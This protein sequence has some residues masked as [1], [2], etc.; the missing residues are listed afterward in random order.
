MSDQTKSQEQKPVDVEAIVAKALYQ[1]Q[2]QI[3]QVVTFMFKE[4]D[5][6]AS[7]F[8]KAK[9]AIEALQKENEDLKE[10]LKAKK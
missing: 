2:G 9:D 6:L 10:K 3:T 4:Y 1:C 7:E 8:K 5:S